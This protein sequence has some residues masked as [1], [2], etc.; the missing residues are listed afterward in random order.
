MQKEGR[1]KFIRIPPLISVIISCY[2]YGR[3]LEDAVNSLIGGKTSLGDTPGQ[4]LQ[5]F[6]IIIVDDASTDN[7]AE[8]AKKLVS[9]SKAIRFIQ[10]K[11]NKGTAATNN[12]G[13]RAAKGFYLTV[14]CA[15]DM[16]EPL[17]LEKLVRP[18]IP[19]KKAFTYDDMQIFSSGKRKVDINGNVKAW[20]MEDF[21]FEKLLYK[22]HIHAGIMFTKEAF[23]VTGGYPEQFGNGR[24]DWA[25]NINL[26]K[27]GYC[28]QHI[29]YVG[30]LYRRE[31]QNRTLENTTPEWRE[32]F[33]AKLQSIYPDLYSG[34]YPMGCC[35]NRS[36]AS[37]SSS[38]GTYN[39]SN[40]LPGATGMTLIDYIGG[41]DGSQTYWG[42]ITGVGY[43]FSKKKYRRNVDDR[44][45][46]TDNDKG[47]LD[48]RQNKKNLF[49]MAQNPVNSVPV[50]ETP[51]PVSVPAPVIPVKTAG[52]PLIL[53]DISADTVAA[54][55]EAGIDTMEDFLS[56]SVEYLVD[57]TSFTK[58]KVKALVA[59]A[60]AII[61]GS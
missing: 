37:K 13:L 40:V 35:G 11:E 25:Y 14:M 53:P 18:L 36:V 5:S 16:R 48:L 45:L 51:A 34:R 57:V 17:S 60:K 6:E 22:N 41:N 55:S 24:E 59:T 23:D 54:L 31:G 19:N 7:S 61:N 44:D 33:L 2:N 52:T 50:P 8:L 28:G 49:T 47:L 21:D 42:P 27:Y 38:A 46:Y 32:Y 12:T 20:K 9:E 43:V 58:A 56:E 15:D 30:Y 29:D 3:Y 1:G 26:G 39:S 10:H 4:T